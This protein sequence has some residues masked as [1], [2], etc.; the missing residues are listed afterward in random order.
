MKVYTLLSA[1]ITNKTLLG[2]IKWQE[3]AELFPTWIRDTPNHLV[4]PTT[5]PKIEPDLLW[6]DFKLKERKSFV[7]SVV[8]FLLW[9]M[10]LFFVYT[11]LSRRSCTE[12]IK[13]GCLNCLDR[14]VQSFRLKIR[15]RLD[16]W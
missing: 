15:T 6:D 10:D 8:R 12:A 11:P 3:C 7:E 14:S 16:R 9:R 5:I 13:L 1:E 2:G 4:G